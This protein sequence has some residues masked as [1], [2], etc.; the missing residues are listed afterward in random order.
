[1][2]L[3]NCHLASSWMPTLQKMC[4]MLEESSAVN[5]DFRLFL[6]S[7]PADYFPVPVLQN[8][9]KLTMEPPKG[10]RANVKRSPNCCDRSR[11]SGR[12][13]AKTKRVSGHLTWSRASIG[14]GC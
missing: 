1:V 12:L 14:R 3:Q 9:V 6:T 13:L 4:E 5:T 8:G 2:L 10:L 11:P 7:M